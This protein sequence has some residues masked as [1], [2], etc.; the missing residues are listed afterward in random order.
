[1]AE[2][3]ENLD[4]WRALYETFEV[5]ARFGG[6]VPPPTTEDLDRFEVETGIRL[7]AGYRGYIRVFGPGCLTVGAGDS[8]REMFIRSPYCPKPSM[9]LGKAVERLRILKDDPPLRMDEQT[10]R[11]VVFATNGHGDEFAWDPLDVTD[12]LAPEFWMYAWYRDDY[13]VKICKT[14]HGFILR[15]TLDLRVRHNHK[16]KNQ[17]DPNRPVSGD[18]SDWGVIG[19]K[20]RRLFSPTRKP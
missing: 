3:D 14:F 18:E 13:S 16:Y 7:P 19:K 15:Y 6:P 20:Q 4:Q 11:T 8:A 2:A 1:M 12:P 17:R 9:D 10:R 5:D